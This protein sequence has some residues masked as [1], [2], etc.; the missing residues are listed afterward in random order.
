MKANLQPFR[1][2]FAIAT[3]TKYFCVS[4]VE[5]FLKK[6]DSSSFLLGESTLYWQGKTSGMNRS[7]KATRQ[8]HTRTCCARLN[9]INL[10][11][12]IR[13]T[14]LFCTQT[15]VDLRSLMRV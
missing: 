3:G 13:S 9:E 2:T 7:M 10:C 4:R 12:L 5:F 6:R 11:F 15:E 1:K 8:H 14:M